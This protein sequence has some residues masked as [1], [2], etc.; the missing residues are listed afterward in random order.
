MRHQKIHFVGLLLQ[1]EHVFYFFVEINQILS[2][3]CDNFMEEKNNSKSEMKKL[4]V[5]VMVLA[6]LISLFG[7]KS[8][9]DPATWNDKKIN[10]WFEKGDWLNGWQVTPDAS[11]NR[12]EFAIVYFKNK[13]R[14]D[15]AFSFLKSN[16][17]NQLENKRFDIDGDNLYAIVSEY[18]T[19][20]EENANFEA[21]RNYVD[22]Q[23][24]ISGEEMI[25][26][27]P[28]TQKQNVITP[29]DA[30]KDIEFMTVA[31]GLVV[32]ATPDRFFLFFPS[33]AHRPSL[34]VKENSHVK[35]MVVKVKLD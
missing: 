34:K 35:K 19:K 22:I 15:K 1:Q 9:T 4:I 21:H 14:W 3:I 5:K 20:N 11:I 31:P 6:S 28:L 30:S 18:L 8:S 16:D 12:K 25:G 27:T 10:K 33:D 26:I 2:H 32:K 17:L 13:E 23:Y 24:V 7:F 29:Y